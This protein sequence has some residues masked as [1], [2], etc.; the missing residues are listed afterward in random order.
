MQTLS[1]AKK[2]ILLGDITLILLFASVCKENRCILYNLAIS[3][4]N[5]YYG[6]T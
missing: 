1:M 3:F 2:Q 5:M 6:E 4:L